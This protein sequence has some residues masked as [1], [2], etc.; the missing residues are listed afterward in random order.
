VE[1]RYSSKR[2]RNI[3]S[4]KGISQV[5]AITSVLSEPDP[6]GRSVTAKLADLG[7]E[8]R[9]PL[10]AVIGLST[11]LSRQLYG[12]LTDK[13]AEYVAQIESSGRHL[14]ALVGDILDLAK[15]EADQLRTEVVD[16]DVAEVV[17]ASVAMIR[18]QATAGGLTVSV[19]LPAGLPAIQ[20]DPLRARQMLLNLLSNAVKFTPSGGRIGVR[21]RDEGEMIAVEVWDSGIG[22]ADEHL[23]RVFEPFEQIDSP[24][25]RQH[26]GTGLGLALTR[27]LAG[28]QG[29]DLTVRSD[30]GTGSTFTATF[31]TGAPAAD[32]ADTTVPG[33]IWLPRRRTRDR[34]PAG[35]GAPGAKLGSGRFYAD[36]PGG[37]PAGGRD[38][39]H[40]RDLRRHRRAPAGRGR[41]RDP[42]GRAEPD[43]RDRTVGGTPGLV[44]TGQ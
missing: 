11:I 35:L 2:H 27:R 10:N 5:T 29:G 8:L 7:H 38:L 39:D 44:P 18:E 26:A 36:V 16:V 32:G 23:E 4:K 41:V 3:F 34:M 37:R 25:A 31:P 13:Q 21:A 15:V 9:T 43:H 12:P 6:A 42:G 14:L 28:L 22:I 19:D 1:L 17:E 20:A 33:V 40:R 24:L 30:L